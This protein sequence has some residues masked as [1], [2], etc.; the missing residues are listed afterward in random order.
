MAPSHCWSRCAAAFP[1]SDTSLPIA[2]IAAS[3]S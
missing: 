3:N 1:S 2:S